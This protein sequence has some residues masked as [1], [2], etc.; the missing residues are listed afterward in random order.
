MDWGGMFEGIGNTFLAG[1]NVNVA[2][3]NERI[4]RNRNE[5][6]KMAILSQEQADKFNYL[7]NDGVNDNQTIKITV[8]GAVI[9]LLLFLLL[10]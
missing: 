6:S 3:I 4:D 10:K 1:S 5:T 9:I 8:I 2:K 7:L